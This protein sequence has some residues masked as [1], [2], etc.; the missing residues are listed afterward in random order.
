MPKDFYSI[1][2]VSQTASIKE[3]KA[4]YRKL[5]LKFHPDTHDGDPS[6]TAEFRRISEAYA[7]LS[8]QD[9]KNSYDFEI[10]IR[11]NK[12]RRT[13]P[14]PNY[15]WEGEIMTTV[16]KY[17]SFVFLHYEMYVHIRF[18]FISDQ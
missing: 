18:T 7:T 8:N 14:P 9:K 3:I 1:L 12:N 13:A 2:R 11:Y 6:K 4:S 10:G 15:R 16:S 5:A 17:S